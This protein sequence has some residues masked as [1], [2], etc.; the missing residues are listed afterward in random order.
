MARPRDADLVSCRDGRRSPG[1]L[2]QACGACAGRPLRCL[3]IRTFNRIPYTGNSR[4]YKLLL[5]SQVGQL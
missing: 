1:L 4:M 2:P 5:F 3:Y